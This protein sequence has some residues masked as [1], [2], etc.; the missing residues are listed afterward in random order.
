MNLLEIVQQRVPGKPHPTPGFNAYYVQQ[1]D[2]IIRN[3][4]KRRFGSLKP[5]ISTAVDFEIFANHCWD[6]L[7]DEGGLKLLQLKTFNGDEH[8]RRYIIIYF[9]RILQ[10][11]I[12]QQAPGL[13]TRVRQIRNLLKE[14][15]VVK[16]INK[17]RFWY[18]KTW[19]GGTHAD[20]STDDMNTDL[21][22]IKLKA[23]LDRLHPPDAIYPRQA[24]SKYGI[25]IPENQMKVYLEKLFHEAGNIISENALISLIAGYYLTK[26][27]EVE[28]KQID[29]D[30]SAS[31]EEPADE[32]EEDIFSAIIS[33][34][35]LFVAM[36]NAVRSFFGLLTDRQKTIF[37]LIYADGL[38]QTD[39]AK[40]LGVSNATISNDEKR[41]EKILTDSIN[42]NSF[43][44]AEAE[45][46]ME[47]CKVEIINLE[48]AS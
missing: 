2:R 24:D 39:A 16:K 4:Y 37:K 27:S 11:L 18:A 22:L 21:E 5:L 19:N 41:I 7:E 8:L 38:R 42:N 13:E 20:L 14:F 29:T 43:Q 31:N 46:F 1:I 6:K 32:T 33:D 35:F 47:V 48:C 15:C 36:R 34:G 30:S 23:T 17:K 28:Q 9:Q 3:V 25:E 40:K 10:N 45:Q 44:F 26:P 12:Y